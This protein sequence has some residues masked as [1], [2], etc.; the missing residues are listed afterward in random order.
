MVLATGRRHPLFFFGVLGCLVRAGSGLW[1]KL[2]FVGGNLTTCVHSFVF[3]RLTTF[4]YS[5]SFT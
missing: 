4:H 1:V 5:L 3:Y 2:Y